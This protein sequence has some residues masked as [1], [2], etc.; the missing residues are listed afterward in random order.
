MLWIVWLCLNL[1]VLG[2]FI[3]KDP[4]LHNLI[5]ALM[6]VSLVLLLVSAFA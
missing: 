1:V 5:A 6:L 3:R 2:W 4:M